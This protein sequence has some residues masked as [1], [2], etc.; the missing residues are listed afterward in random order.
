[1]FGGMLIE[2]K[3]LCISG[4]ETPALASIP[5]SEMPHVTFSLVIPSRYLPEVPQY[6]N[7]K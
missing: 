5:F 2:H 1:V 3:N 7:Q 4:N 6:K